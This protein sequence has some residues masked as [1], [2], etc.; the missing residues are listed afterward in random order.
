MLKAYLS[1]QASSL[2]A[3]AIS[4]T[5]ISGQKPRGR[6]LNTKVCGHESAIFLI[7]LYFFQQRYLANGLSTHRHFRTK[8]ILVTMRSS[9]TNWHLHSFNF[10]LVNK[11]HSQHSVSAVR[12]E[13]CHFVILYACTQVVLFQILG[14]E[15]GNET[16][17]KRNRELTTGTALAQSLPAVGGKVYEHHR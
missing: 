3:F 14:S 7:L 5:H 2:S 11:S 15:S 17:H 9:T 8:L 10:T 16:N 13:G 12:C 6:Q 1:V 4:K